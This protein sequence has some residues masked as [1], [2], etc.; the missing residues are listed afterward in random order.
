MRRALLAV[1]VGGALGAVLRW[2]LGLLAP[3]GQGFPWTTFAI[4][5]SGSFL[6]ALL[7]ALPS[8]RRHRLLPLFLGTGVLGGYT[9][10]STYAE[11][12]RVL[13]ADG[14]AGLALAYLLGTLAAC[15]MAVWLARHLSPPSAQLEFAVEGGEE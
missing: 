4:N 12:S 3:D 9:T 5:V 10:L 7:P 11:E 13:F 1:A 6:L 2:S 8:V 14:R 15:V